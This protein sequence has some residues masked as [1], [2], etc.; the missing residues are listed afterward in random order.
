M[1]VKEVRSILE[2]AV[3]V[4]HSGLTRKQ[5][6]E[7]E[8]AQKTAFIIILRH[9]YSSYE[10]ACAIFNTHTLEERRQELCLR[11]AKKN[12]N[13]ENSFFTHRKNELNLRNRKRKVEEF[14]CRT[15]RFQRS[16]LPYLRPNF[17]KIFTCLNRV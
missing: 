7:I 5:T 6:S 2:Y 12:L 11:F 13:S 16:S 8:S 1:Y 4:W 3:P 17:K 14:K 10:S 15:A 9:R